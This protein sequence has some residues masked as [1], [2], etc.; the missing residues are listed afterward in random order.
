MNGLGE[1]CLYGCSRVQHGLELL[2]ESLPET[3]RDR[4]GASSA[5]G[6]AIQPDQRQHV[7]AGAGE[8]RFIPAITLCQRKW[9]ALHGDSQTIGQLEHLLLRDTSQN[10]LRWCR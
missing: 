5:D 3:V 7:P 8:K 4:T 6:L 1:P 10:I 9:S 2:L